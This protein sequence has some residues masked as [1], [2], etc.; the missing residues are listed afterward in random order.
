MSETTTET[1]TE[2]TE[3]TQGDPADSPLGEGGAKALV[4]EREARKAAEKAAAALQKQLDD[5]NAANLSDLEKAQNAAKAAEEAATKASTE[6]LRYRIAAE[7]GIKE[8][9][10]LILTASD[11]ETMRKQAALWVERTPTG[12]KPDPSQGAK[13]SDTK[14]STAD[15]FAA[16]IDGAFTR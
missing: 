10:D 7:S 2:T 8:H 6:A 5:I 1:T 4:A 15:Q 9:A 12:L 3:K 13:G 11:E 16:A 14:A